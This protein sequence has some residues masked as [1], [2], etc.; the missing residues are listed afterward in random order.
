MK[1]DEIDAALEH[2]SGG[3]PEEKKEEHPPQPVAVESEN[4]K[5]EPE[6][7][8]EANK[9]VQDGQSQPKGYDF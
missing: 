8:S 6:E 1:D 3:T 2:L 9:G 4:N 7:E 5:K